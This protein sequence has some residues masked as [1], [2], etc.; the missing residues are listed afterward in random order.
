MELENRWDK[1]PHSEVNI[2]VIVPGSDQEAE[3]MKEKKLRLEF[4]IQAVRDL[5]IHQQFDLVEEQA[6]QI[7]LPLRD[8]GLV[9]DGPNRSRC[10]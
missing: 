1:L 4:D 2:H 3:Q 10:P 6:D 7:L 9:Q 5:K 8:H